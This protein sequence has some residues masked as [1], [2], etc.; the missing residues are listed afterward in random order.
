MV[1][2]KNQFLIIKVLYNE[3]KDCKKN[4]YVYSKLLKIKLRVKGTVE[5]SYPCTGYYS[6]TTYPTM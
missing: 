2:S 5:A 4:W 1:F 6:Y 3:N